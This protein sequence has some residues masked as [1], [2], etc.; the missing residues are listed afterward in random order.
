MKSPIVHKFMRSHFMSFLY[1]HGL[2]RPMAPAAGVACT[3][4]AGFHIRLGYELGVGFYDWTGNGIRLA[5]TITTSGRLKRSLQADIVQPD[6]L[7]LNALRSELRNAAIRQMSKIIQAAR[8]NGQGVSHH[9]LV[10]MRNAQADHLRVPDF[11]YQTEEDLERWCAIVRPFIPT[12]VAALKSEAE[13]L[14]ANL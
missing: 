8:Q 6:D 7:L 11:R 4:H 2:V 9:L 5:G 3:N 10:E 12:C 13:R 1:E 14:R